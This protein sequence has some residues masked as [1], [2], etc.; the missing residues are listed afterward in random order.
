MPS[1]PATVSDIAL[2]YDELDHLY[3]KMWGPHLHHGLWIK[4]N[5]TRKKA[6]LNL[7]TKVLAGIGTIKGAHLMDIGCGYGETSRLALKRGAG[8]VSG[9]T[10]SK[11][12]LDYALKRSHGMEASF[13][14]GDWNENTFE[15]ESFDG[16]FSI[17]CFSHIKDKDKYFKEVHRTLR[18]GGRFSMTAWLSKN[19][20][21]RL[22]D[23]FLLSPIC[24]E[25][26][27]PSLWTKE[28]VLSSAEKA[29][30]R[31]LRNENLSQ[32]VEKTWSLCIEELFKLT[33]SQEGVRFFLSRQNQQRP[34][35]L[36]LFRLLLGY[37]LKCFEYGS[38]IFSKELK[39]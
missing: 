24:H 3:R 7:S 1:S 6:V 11:R 27:L 31:C 39:S 17:E 15:S 32:Q 29:G 19:N 35:A 37:R 8:K 4:G 21:S 34:F 36:T 10:L 38:F 5:E 13:Y 2:H 28:E 20:P 30:L 14:L 16:A 25:G 22:E 23:K 26:K 12:Q 9:M 33:F 18:S